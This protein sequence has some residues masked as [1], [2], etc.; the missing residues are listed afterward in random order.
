MSVQMP[1]SSGDIRPFYVE[2]SCYQS[3]SS[4]HTIF[5]SPSGT[6]AVASI[7]IAPAPRMA[8]AYGQKVTFL[9]RLHRVFLRLLTPM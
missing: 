3:S 5:V 8:N 4:V 7:Q 2:K 1:A 9:N 6:T